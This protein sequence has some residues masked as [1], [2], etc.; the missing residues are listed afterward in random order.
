[1]ESEI[2]EARGGR[3]MV[4]EHD[5]GRCSWDASLAEAMRRHPGSKGLDC[6]SV[7]PHRETGKFA[8]LGSKTGPMV[9]NRVG[10]V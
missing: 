10:I 7:R 4:I 5:P 3:F 2:R 8:G 6:V 1:M 9:G